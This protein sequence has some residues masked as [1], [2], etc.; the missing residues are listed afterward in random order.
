MQPLK[1]AAYLIYLPIPKSYS[2]QEEEQGLSLASIVRFEF[3]NF[4]QHG[5]LAQSS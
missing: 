4:I 3:L 5:F 2:A 1:Y